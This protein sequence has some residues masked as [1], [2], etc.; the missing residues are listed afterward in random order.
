M[1]SSNTHL[2]KGRNAVGY[3]SEQEDALRALESAAKAIRASKTPK[4]ESDYGS[5][6]RKCVA[7]GVKPKLKSKW[8]G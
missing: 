1:K 3:T 6:Y 2:L 7:L 4:A 5:A 8:G